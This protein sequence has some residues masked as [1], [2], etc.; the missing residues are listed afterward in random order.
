GIFV[1]GDFDAFMDDGRGRKRGDSFF[2]EY[3][4]LE[5]EA[6]LF[7]ADA[8]SKKSSDFKAIHMANFIDSSYYTL[9]NTSK[10]QNELIRSERMCRLD[11][12]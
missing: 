1:N 12:R 10:C 5:T 7:V 3:P 11:L 8:C 4:E 9:L 2:D 6:K